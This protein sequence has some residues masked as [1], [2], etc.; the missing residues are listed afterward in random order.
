MLEL[1]WVFKMI[2]ALLFSVLVIVTLPQSALAHSD[3]DLPLRVDP[4]INEMMAANQT[5]G[6]MR[7]ACV[8]ALSREPSTRQNSFEAGMCLLLL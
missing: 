5:I 4:L 2:R 6:G 3:Q 1:R 7:K 8:L